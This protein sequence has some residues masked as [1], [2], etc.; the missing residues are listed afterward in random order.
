MKSSFS[1]LD[2]EF[3][4]ESPIEKGLDFAKKITNVILWLA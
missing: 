1:K 2:V 4:P 3:L